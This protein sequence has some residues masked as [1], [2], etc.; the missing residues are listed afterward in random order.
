MWLRKKT[1]LGF[2]QGLLITETS[3]YYTTVWKERVAVSFQRFQETNY[4]QSLQGDLNPQNRC[5]I[6]GSWL[7]PWSRGPCD[8]SR[9]YITRFTHVRPFLLTS[10]VICREMQHKKR[11]KTQEEG[12]ELEKEI[13]KSNQ[14]A[15]VQREREKE[16]LRQTPDDNLQ[17]VTLLNETWNSRVFEK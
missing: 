11:K 4:I 7:P 8:T 14:R 5:A 10:S 1:K 16:R 9:L 17:A 12:E 15:W 3:F 13:K 2:E 6:A